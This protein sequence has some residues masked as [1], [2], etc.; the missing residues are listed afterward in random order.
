MSIGDFD[1]VL[2]AYK[3]REWGKEKD[4]YYEHPSNVSYDNDSDAVEEMQEEDE[5]DVDMEELVDDESEI[6]E[7]IE[8]EDEG[9][10]SKGNK[11]EDEESLC[12]DEEQDCKMHQLLY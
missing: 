8:E 10:Q 5:S 4:F 12:A 3:E 9:E 2:G 1:R 6:S 11:N 7:M